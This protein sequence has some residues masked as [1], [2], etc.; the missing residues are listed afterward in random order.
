[1]AKIL[2]A[3]DDSSMR[4]FLTKALENA[5]HSV[6]ACEDGLAAL[7]KIKASCDYDLLLTDIVMPGI[8]G[9]ELSQKASDICPNL[10]VMFITG[11]T[12]VAVNHA[13]EDQDNQHRVISKPFHLRDLIENV[14]V[15]LRK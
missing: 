5:N 1:M 2:L 13:T 6:I 12:A 10:K 11:F 9:I 8:D 14:N 7:E 15:V 3:E 4:S